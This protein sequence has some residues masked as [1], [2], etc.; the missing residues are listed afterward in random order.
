MKQFITIL[1]TA[2]V[3]VFAGCTAGSS[4]KDS[5]VITDG[6]ILEDGDLTADESNDIA[7]D[8]TDSVAADKDTAKPDNY[9]KD[10]VTVK[11]DV[12]TDT[13]TIVPVDETPDM[14]ETVVTDEA[15]DTDETVVNDETVDTDETVVADETVDTDGAEVDTDIEVDTDVEIDTDIE[16]DTDITV[17]DEDTTP[18]LVIGW[19]NTQSPVDAIYT[20]GDSATVLGQVFI[21]NIT[22]ST[23][24]T[25]HVSDPAYPQIIGQ[26]GF[27]APGTSALSWDSGNWSPVAALP[28]EDKGNNDEYIIGP[29][30][31]NMP[32]GTYDF[33]FRFSGDFGNT[34]TYCNINGEPAYNGTDSTHP[35]DLAKNG[36]L[37]V[38]AVYVDPCTPVNTCAEDHRKVCTDTNLDG[39]AECACDTDYTLDGGSVC[40][41]SKQVQCDI[42]NENPLNSSDVIANVTVVY[43][44]EDGWADRAKCDWT[45]NLH[46]TKDGSTC[47]ADSQEVSCT[48]SL[49]ANANWI[50]PNASGKITQTWS[51]EAWLPASDSCEWE[52]AEHYTKNGNACDA[53]KQTV[54]CTNTLP[55]HAVWIL[56]NL[57]GEI[58]QTWD[59]TD[60]AP[61]DD[62]CDWECDTDYDVFDG[63][64]I[65][66]Q[67]VSCDTNNNNPEHSTDTIVNVEIT[68]T[69]EGGWT[70]R[71]KCEWACDAVYEK[72]EDT[73]VFLFA[74]GDGTIDNPYQIATAKQL[75]SVRNYLNKYFIQVADIDLHPD[76]LATE[77]WY[78]DTN[79][80]LPIGSGGSSFTGI[81]NGDGYVI[82]NLTIDRTTDYTGLFGIV[83]SGGIL[84]NMGIEDCIISGDAWVG[85][86]VGYNNGTV[87]F[88]YSTGEIYGG[89]NTG[90]IAGRNTGTIEYSYSGAYV[91]GSNFAGGAAGLNSGTV[92]NSYAVGAVTG[93]SSVGGLV[94]YNSGIGEILNSYSIGQVNGTTDT[95][96]LVGANSGTVTNGFYNGDTAGQDDEGKGTPL[97]SENM[98]KQATFTDADWN[99]SDI[100]MIDEGE[101]YP[102]FI[103]SGYTSGAGILEGAL[104]TGSAI[105]PY[106]IYTIGQL[107]NVRNHL[108][109]HF[110][111]MADI[112]FSVIDGIAGWMPIGDFNNQ[113]TGSYNGAGKAISY[114]FISRSSS[115]QIGLFGVVG[116][117][118][119]IENIAL[120]NASI[121]GGSTVGGIAGLNYGKVRYCYVTGEV[122][123]TLSVG[124]LVG[125]NHE[126]IVNDSYSTADVSGTDYVGG[127][128]G[129]NY[130]GTISNCYAAGFVS[131]KTKA[132]VP[133]ANTG[134]LVGISASGT[135]LNSFYD[136]DV[137]GQIDTGKGTP[138]NTGEMMVQ[139]TF[140]G[141]EFGEAW[142]IDEEASYPYLWW[143]YFPGGIGTLNDPYHVGTAD[144]LDN[145]R[146]HADKHFIQIANIDLSGYDADG[147][148]WMPIGNYSTSFTG[149]YNGNEYIISN[150]FIDRGTANYIGL[151]GITASGSR[152]EN[153]ELRDID[154]T[155]HNIVSGLVAD[156][157]GTIEYCSTTGSVYGNVDVGGIAGWNDPG[158]TITGSHSTASIEGTSG[159]SGNI[160]GLVGRNYGTIAESYAA[161]SVTG[162]NYVGGLAGTNVSSESEGVISKCFATGEVTGD[163]DVGG[164][165]GSLSSGSISDSYASAAVSGVN[166]IGGLVGAGYG[167]TIDN[168]F[169]TGQVSVTAKIPSVYKGGL[170]GYNGGVTVSNSFY[171]KETTGQSDNTGKGTPKTTIEMKTK[172]TFTDAGWDFTPDGI[173]AIDDGNSYPTL[174]WNI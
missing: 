163:N 146:Y 111:Q 118:G 23:T 13:D 51:G 109:K 105:H 30:P 1:L 43:T 22:A 139:A 36:H 17:P 50:A 170:M 107:D 77:S 122:T 63:T 123:G 155:G 62:S 83:G 85:I 69:T 74:G 160:G 124:G 5:D 104:R 135:V 44:T 68:Y 168:C 78:D 26:V 21:E 99:F 90:G 45:C 145:V 131:Q 48:N 56:P 103:W 59:G 141:W 4:N 41:H 120:T 15:S 31:M 79:G 157:G 18:P 42:E 149:S 89:S 100:W 169:A 32:V 39:T 132:P 133:S 25:D 88:S 6:I 71:T 117:K 166:Y 97:D 134:G 151:F 156:N 167:D 108:K 2:V 143:Q 81:Y 84:K 138:K 137:S 53:D 116:A 66:S 7:S 75:N 142:L 10:T 33:V 9:D 82:S 65:N 172:T 136:S 34:W 47:N 57:D 67:I 96:G 106:E 54:A 174:M 28:N 80:W 165:V 86:F 46:Y 148:G 16:V 129:Y 14:D 40:I 19:C 158:A 49:P 73:C 93:E 24:I 102:Y 126:A 60:W 154:V 173:W 140:T 115:N 147:S 29:V 8:A 55:D 125:E 11:D 87:S 12:N 94:G 150:L 37:T 119:M 70:P 127:L 92:S 38:K 72:T 130:I 91:E 27:G 76:V 128:V 113:F 98:K 152:I 52:C 171:D 3:F 20:V 161:G 101:S 61:A 95:G 58:E 162:H 144:E 153:V 35:Y 112:D 114:L 110:I 64:C 164:L 121:S 159:T